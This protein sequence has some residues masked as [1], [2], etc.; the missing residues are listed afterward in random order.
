MSRD[1]RVYLDDILESV[2]KVDRYLSGIS[3]EAFENDSMRIDA[4]VHNLQIIGEAARKIPDEIRFKYP[5]V[6]WRK[7]VGFR[8]NAV[9][10]YF[11]V[12]LDTVWAII[13]EEIPKL[14]VQISEILEQE[15]KSDSR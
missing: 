4:V 7:I 9:H 2:Q 14:K 8:N 12:N 6:E 15:D 13:E 5:Q 3:F 11:R 1:Y 10:E